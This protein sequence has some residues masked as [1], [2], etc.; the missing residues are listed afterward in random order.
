VVPGLRPAQAYTEALGEAFPGFG[1]AVPKTSARAALALH[2]SLTAREL[3]LLTVEGEPPPEAL[4]V[5]TAGGP[6][7]LHPEEAAV[8]PA[9][10][11]RRPH[12]ETPF[13]VH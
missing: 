6:L 12:N 7:W 3:E 11:G 5:D 13:G 2:R 9:P 4:R 8:H 10:A 1:T